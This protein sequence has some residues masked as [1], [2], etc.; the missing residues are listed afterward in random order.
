MI[1][2]TTANFY[3]DFPYLR[4]AEWL[5]NNIDNYP[6]DMS[7]TENYIYPL[8]DF[9]DRLDKAIT[10]HN[11]AQSPTLDDIKFYLDDDIIKNIVDILLDKI[12]YDNI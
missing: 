12:L 3:N 5:Y 11:I 4:I 10:K 2:L 1:K 6:L 9:I 7:D 8:I